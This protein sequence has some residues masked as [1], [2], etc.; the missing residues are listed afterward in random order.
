MTEPEFLELEQTTPWA[1]IRV[2]E[3]V[4]SLADSRVLAEMEAILSQVREARSAGV[5]IDLEQA[6]YFGSSLLE[7]LRLLW[8]D[9]RARGENLVLCNV[10]AVGREILEVAKFDRIWPLTGNRSDAMAQL[11]RMGHSS[12]EPPILA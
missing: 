4:T 11:D 2:R 9:L 10:S 5:I 8:K 6:A 1:V 3:A 12:G 7:A